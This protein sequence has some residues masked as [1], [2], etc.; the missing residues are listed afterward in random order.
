MSVIKR[1]EARR[2]GLRK[3]DE[4]TNG[5]TV[6][7]LGHAA[8]KLVAIELESRTR[9]EIP[10]GRAC[11][12]S[13]SL[14]PDYFPSPLRVVGVCEFIGDEG[15]V[16]RIQALLVY[17]CGRRRTDVRFVCSCSSPS[18]TFFSS[19]QRLTRPD[20]PQTG[21]DQSSSSSSML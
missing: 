12:Q 17:A 11:G 16:F 7:W 10:R 18:S 1:E 14:P 3:D 4:R 5:Q 20:Q 6:G 21:T 19:E 13:H 8:M 2:I 9:E 15:R